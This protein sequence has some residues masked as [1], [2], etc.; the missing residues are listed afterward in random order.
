MMKRK[1]AMALAVSMVVGSLAA[2][3][4]KTDQAATTAAPKAE[5]AQGDQSGAADGGAEAALR[6]TP[7]RRMIPNR[8][9]RSSGKTT[10]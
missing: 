4:G 6:L 2:C 3:G 5:N 9:L 10:A 8:P 1:L 7:D